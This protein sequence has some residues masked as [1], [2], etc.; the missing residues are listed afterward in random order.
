M[1]TTEPHPQ[2]NRLSR[3]FLDRTLNIRRRSTQNLIDL[4]SVLEVDESRHGADAQLLR[5]V[6]DLVDVDLVERNVRVLFA[7]FGDL[8]GDGLAGATPGSEAVD[9]DQL[10]VVGGGLELGGFDGVVEV[11]AAGRV[12]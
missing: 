9:H 10:G 7:V 4:L 12:G 1:R 6:G 11:G 2:P 5:D 8:G 3:V